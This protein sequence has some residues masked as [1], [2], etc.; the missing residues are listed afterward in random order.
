M[1]GYIDVVEY[2][3]DYDNFGNEFPDRVRHTVAWVNYDKGYIIYLD[4]LTNG[5]FDTCVWGVHGDGGPDDKQIPPVVLCTL[6]KAL[7]EY[8]EELGYEPPV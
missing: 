6:Y 3:D 8:E 2:D 4:R 1:E 5:A 7:A